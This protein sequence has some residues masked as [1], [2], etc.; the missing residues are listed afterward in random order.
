LD[1]NS[2]ANSPNTRRIIWVPGSYLDPNRGAYARCTHTNYR[3]NPNAIRQD[4]Q[5]TY[6]WNAVNA[7]AVRKVLAKVTVPLEGVCPMMAV[8]SEDFR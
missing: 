2:P 6:E 4:I 1:K 5:G 7:E 3:P 8:D